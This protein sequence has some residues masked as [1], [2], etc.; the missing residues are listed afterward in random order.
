MGPRSGA[1]L[2]WNPSFALSLTC[3]L[4]THLG[5]RVEA[6][7]GGGGVVRPRRQSGGGGGETGWLGLGGRQS[8]RVL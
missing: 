4:H 8:K 2:A 7:W 1:H 5:G 3:L 6:E